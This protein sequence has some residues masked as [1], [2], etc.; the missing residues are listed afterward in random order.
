MCLGG[1]LHGNAPATCCRGSSRCPANLPCTCICGDLRTD[2]DEVFRIKNAHTERARLVCVWH[3]NSSY[4][5]RRSNISGDTPWPAANDA[6]SI[7][8]DVRTWRHRMASKGTTTTPGSSHDVCLEDRM[9]LPR[10]ARKPAVQENTYWR[11]TRAY[12][13]H[14]RRKRLPVQRLSVMPR[15]VPEVSLAAQRVIYVLCAPQPAPQPG[16]ARRREVGQQG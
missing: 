2:C 16:R 8:H 1:N 7:H 14:T 9:C 15:F 12:R 11:S 13:M 4:L 3:G 10:R 5:Q 6:S